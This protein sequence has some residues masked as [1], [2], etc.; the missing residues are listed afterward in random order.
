MLALDPRQWRQGE[1]S[2]RGA[3]TP[4]GTEAVTKPAPAGYLFIMRLLVSGSHRGAC[5]ALA[6]LWTASACDSPVAGPDEQVTQ[7]EGRLIFGLDVASSEW[8]NNLAEL[9][10]IRP[11]GTDG[12]TYRAAAAAYMNPSPQGTHVAFFNGDQLFVGNSDGITLTHELADG[13]DYFDDTH[14]SADGSW[15]AYHRRKVSG[16]IALGVVSRTGTPATDVNALFA[17]TVPCAGGDPETIP[18][19]FRHFTVDRMAFMWSRC[20]APNVYYSIKPDGTELLETANASP[21]WISPDGSRVLYLVAGVPWA[22]DLDG[23]NAGALSTSGGV[24]LSSDWMLP[25]PWSPDGN[26]IVLLR[27]VGTC[28]QPHLLAADGSN[29]RPLADEGCW[30]FHS[31]SPDGQWIAATRTD[32][33]QG[34]VL[35]LLKRDGSEQRTLT[36]GASTMRVMDVAWL[37]TP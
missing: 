29:E 35:H 17:E 14:W 27:M 16:T 13:F 21:Q 23:E 32:V 22:S 4:L 31:W 6:L 1:G 33:H 7:L 37:A 8:P 19:I 12:F 36:L 9:R 26:S 3:A 11:D 30:M 20:G 25:Y 18:L 2:R 24:F 15:V 28:V 5:A 10:A 34:A